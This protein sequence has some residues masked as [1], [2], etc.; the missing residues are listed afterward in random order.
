MKRYRTLLAAAAFG[1]AGSGCIHI[2]L[3]EKDKDKLPAGLLPASATQSMGKTD[4]A[5]TPAAALIPG[6]MVSLPKMMKSG[7][8]KN[9]AVEMSAAWQNRVA[10]LPDPTR[11]GA[12]G[13]GLVGQLFLFSSNMQVA[14]PE[15][16]LTVELFDE[17][18]KAGRPPEAVKLGRWTIDK[19]TLKKFRIQDERWGPCY[20]LFLPWPDYRAD[21][22]RIR[23]TVK[24]E[25]EGGFPI[26]ATPATITLDTSAPGSNTAPPVVNTV[27]PGMQ[28]GFGQMN[29]PMSPL[30]G[31][32]PSGVA[33]MPQTGSTQ[34]P[35]QAFAP[36]P[37]YAKPQ[38]ATYPPTNY[39]PPPAPQFVPPVGPQPMAPQ[40]PMQPM[41]PLPPMG[42]AGS[43]P[44]PT[45]PNGVG[46]SGAP[47]GLPPIA[48]MAGQR[49]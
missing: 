28:G 37:S 48:I 26:Y 23:L 12:M 33:A 5:V 41:A 39:A 14:V 42:A 4:G 44:I 45:P 31:P 6:G 20:A 25:P 35:P 27:V 13:A 18:P 9:Q 7:G 24:Y 34:P 46:M 47:N 2:H 16:P 36:P 29:A 11:E 40:S 17:S 30:G 15:G 3:D 32:P 38:A 19:E 43:M 8:A 21:I 49:R 22:A 1:L 10:Y